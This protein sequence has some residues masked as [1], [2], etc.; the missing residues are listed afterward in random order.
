[1]GEERTRQSTGNRIKVSGL[2]FRFRA[3]GV[4]DLGVEGFRVW[5]MRV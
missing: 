3:L 5:A 1:M 2:G 4:E